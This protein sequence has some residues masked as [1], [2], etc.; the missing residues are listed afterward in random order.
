VLLLSR[1]TAYEHLSNV[2]VAEITTTIRGA[3]T[4]VVLGKGEGLFRRSA[5]NFDSLQTVPK[6]RLYE[7]VGALRPDRIR[8]VKRALGIALDWGELLEI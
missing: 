4:E 8:E 1:R 6:R 2:L 3:P 7:K 5:A